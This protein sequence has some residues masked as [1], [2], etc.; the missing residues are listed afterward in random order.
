MGRTDWYDTWWGRFLYW[1]TLGG[2]L[3]GVW[4]S[5]D[6]TEL[7]VPGVVYLFGF[8]GATVYVFTSF[9]KRFDEDGRYRLKIVSRT[10]AVLPLV[11]GVYLL[12]FAF[13]GVSGELSALNAT[14]TSDGGV[15]S[16]DR[17]VAGLVF[18]AGI[19]VSATLQAL[20]GLAERLLGVSPAQEGGE[21]E[22]EEQSAD[23]PGSGGN[24]GNDEG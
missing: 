19:Y 5:V 6:G 10:V 3:L 21:D 7:Q 23:E 17:V 20:G 15:S 18:L 14:S 24:G 9:A 11:A 1:G 13:P 4:L 22:G 12:A 2:T 8:L 16:A